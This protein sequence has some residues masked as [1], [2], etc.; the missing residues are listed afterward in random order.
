MKGG[1]GC[2]KGVTFLW[3]SDCGIDAEALRALADLLSRGAFPALKTLCFPGKSDITDV[4]VVA[5][6]KGLSKATQTIFTHLHLEDVGMSDEGIA[7]LAALIHKGRLNQ[8]IAM[9][10]SENSL[11]T[12]RGVITLAQAIDAHG[13][14]ILD[15]F[16]TRGIRELTAVEI[17]QLR[18]RSTKDASDS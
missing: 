5:L 13:L 18:R 12:D 8:L 6:V 14:P 17:V 11:V 7:G 1:A 10:L 4:G 16:K 2:A 15:T 3:F 9:H